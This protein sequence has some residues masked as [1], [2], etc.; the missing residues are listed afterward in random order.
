MARLAVLSLHTSPL[1]QPGAGDGGGMNVYVR[2]LAAAL[3]RRGD[4]VDV[5]TRREAEHVRAVVEV[6]PG[7]RVH[8][9]PAGPRHPV[10]KECLVAH[11]EA[12]TAGVLEVLDDLD[13]VDAVHANYWLSGMAG[14]A[15]KHELDVPLLVTFHT[16]E[17]IKS[18]TSGEPLSDRAAAEAA[19][20]ACADAVLASCEV[21][22]A[23]LET[24]LGVPAD[25]VALVPLGVDHAF[26]GPGDRTQAR[27]ALAIDADGP[28]LLFAGRL[29]SLKGADLALATLSELA[30]RGGGHRLVVVGGPSGPEGDDFEASLHD[31]AAEHDVLGRVTFVA[32]RRHELLSTYYRAADV[33]L[34]P[35]RAETF[36][37]VALEASACGAPVVAADVG[38]LAALV[39]DRVT[40]RLVTDRSPTAWAD[41]VQWV[42]A[43][44]LRAMRLS[45]A[46]VLRAREFTWRA[47]AERFDEVVRDARASRLVSCS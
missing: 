32:P 16:A 47:A 41:A 43:D 4:E 20:V 25:R 14:H 21:E 24:V 7:V 17:R 12:F 40:G 5:F 13:R 8:H 36:G 34:V 26:F 29:Q 15:I 22:A 19:I 27:R 46:A 30:R 9:V 45:T 2:E 35:S 44:A 39:D 11:V 38:G 37:L 18:A 33:C 42:T 10:D 31:R 3:A 23:Q 6:E 1:A 28:L